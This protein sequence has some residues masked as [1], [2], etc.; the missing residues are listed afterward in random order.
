MNRAKMIC[1]YCGTMFREERNE[2]R[3]GAYNPWVH[4]LCANA[5]IPKELATS[6]PREMSEFAIRRLAQEFADGIA[7]FMEVQT[8]DEPITNEMLFRA[9]LRVLDSG[10]RYE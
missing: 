5:I 2:L 6:S 10:Y 8:M 4:T 3:V 7:Q 1:E 9:R